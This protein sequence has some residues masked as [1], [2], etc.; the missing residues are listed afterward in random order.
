[1]IGLQTQERVD[2]MICTPH[3]QIRFVSAKVSGSI[4]ALQILWP[5]NPKKFIYNGQ[6]LSESRTFKFY[7]IKSGESIIALPKNSQDA[8]DQWKKVT[9]DRLEFNELVQTMT[10]PVT[11][12]E[13]ARLRDLR[14]MNIERK[15]KVFHRFQNSFSEN[16]EA[17]ARNN[18][19]IAATKSIIDNNLVA[20]SEDALPVLW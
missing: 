2:L 9:S 18:N 13:A 15:A 11:V 7:G 1:M 8:D 14:Y 6:E 17:L 4:K 3:H 5:D 16:N 20:P 12:R 19:P 10:N